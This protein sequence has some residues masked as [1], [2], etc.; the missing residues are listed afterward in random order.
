MK[1]H[2]RTPPRPRLVRGGGHGTP[3]HDHGTPR[4]WH[5][6]TMAHLDHGTPQ[7][8]RRDHGTPRTW[9]TS[10]MAHLG[11]HDTTMAHLGLGTPRIGH[12]SDL[13]HLGLGTPRTWHTSARTT[14][15][16]HTSDLTCRD[17]PPTT[18]GRGG[19][20]TCTLARCVMPPPPCAQ[21]EAEAG[22]ARA[23]WPGVP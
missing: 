1:V 17:P 6:S 14:R 15:P 20:C 9:Q 10:A 2:V 19:V 12:T 3:G 23:P 22:C 8:A 16:W 7:R 4:T 18:R 11:A 21:F 13:A 5:T